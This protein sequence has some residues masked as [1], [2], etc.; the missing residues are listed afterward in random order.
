MTLRTLEIVLESHFC[1]PSSGNC[2]LCGQPYPCDAKWASEVALKNRRLDED[3]YEEG[4]NAGYSFGVEEG[5]QQG[6]DEGYD[7]ALEDHP[8]RAS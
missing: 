4:Y 7:Q 2:Y 5:Y 1:D 8:E 3:D 6:H